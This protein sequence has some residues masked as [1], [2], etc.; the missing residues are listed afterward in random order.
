LN[1]ILVWLREGLD[2]LLPR[3]AAERPKDEDA[4]EPPALTY[5][6]KTLADSYRKEIDQEENV[7]RTL[8][9]FV[10]TL[11]LQVNALVQVVHQFPDLTTNIGRTE[12]GLL[13]LAAVSDLVTL[14]FLG[15][16]IWPKKFTY[17]ARDTALLDYAEDLIE[18]EE[19]AAKDGTD[20][21]PI[22][23]LVTLKWEIAK[24]YAVGADHNRRI[25]KLRERWRARAGLS[26]L[27]AVL[28]T[29]CL[30]GT[31]YGQYVY[32]Y[33]LKEVGHAVVHKPV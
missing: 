6:E 29:I 23:A 30:A 31:I 12:N 19:N 2:R 13:V 16:S 21:K 3:P 32:S 18:A 8:P 25:N 22:S 4:P 11:A 27:F 28:V 26:I 20:D 10:A 33:I 17:L 9:F 1:P 7:W 5:I 15:I 14:G 24:Q